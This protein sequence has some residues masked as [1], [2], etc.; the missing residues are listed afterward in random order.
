[1][2]KEIDE[3]IIRHPAGLKMALGENP[4]RVGTM[5]KRAPT[6]RMG[7]AYLIRKAFYD[8]IDYQVEWDNYNEL[9]SI[10]EGKPEGERKP[11]K[12]PS[13][14]LGKEV[15]IKTLSGEIPVRCHS[16]RADDIRTAIR[17]AEEFGYELIIDHATESY[18]IKEVIARQNIPVAIGPIFMN[19]AKRELADQSM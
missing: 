2:G 6:T 4:K 5:Y 16:H 8:A 9:V 10:E 15:L 1:M 7:V 13:Y 18:K 3:M 17:L 11:V 12:K 19:R 14:D